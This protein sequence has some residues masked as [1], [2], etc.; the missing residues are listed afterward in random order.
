MVRPVEMKKEEEKPKNHNNMNH[1]SVGRLN[2]WASGK[3]INKFVVMPFT[4]HN[5][6]D[7]HFNCSIYQGFFV[8]SILHFVLRAFLIA[9]KRIMMLLSPKNKC[10]TSSIPRFF[11]HHS[12]SSLNNSSIGE[13]SSLYNLFCFV[14]HMRLN[15][16]KQ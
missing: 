15:A 6:I 8:L 2:F 5:C 7:L 13:R 9:R 3:R 4:I 1:Y 12:V 10:R 16:G 14:F 11:L